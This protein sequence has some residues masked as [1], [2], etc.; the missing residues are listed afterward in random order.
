MTASLPR[1]TRADSAEGFTTGLCT[2]DCVDSRYCWDI[3][4]D[5]EALRD[6][7]LEDDF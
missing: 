3:L 5:F 4:S 1:T 2:S 6:T 7:V